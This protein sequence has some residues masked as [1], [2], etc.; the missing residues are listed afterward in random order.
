M[1]DEPVRDWA[2][3]ESGESRKRLGFRVYPSSASFRIV[4]AIKFFISKKPKI[5]PVSLWE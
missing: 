4:S 5:D 3:L 2:R 1:E